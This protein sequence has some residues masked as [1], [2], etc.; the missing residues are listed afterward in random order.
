[1]L[2]SH[3]LNVSSL[4]S[5]PTPAVGSGEPKYKG[6]FYILA[7]II[8]LFCP[9]QE[10]LVYFSSDSAPNT[11]NGGKHPQHSCSKSCLHE[12]SNV[13]YGQ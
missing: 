5:V 7:F 2:L 6:F 12:G 3:S 13:Q 10:R 4:L 1:M 8:K 9:A 11:F